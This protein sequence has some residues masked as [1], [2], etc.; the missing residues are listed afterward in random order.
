MDLDKLNKRAWLIGMLR[1][2][3]GRYPPKYLTKIEA[4][5]ERGKYKCS[6]CQELFGPKQIQIDHTVPVID[7]EK[8][9]TNWD[10]YINRMF[11]DK[12]GF[13]AM[14]KPCHKEKSDKENKI[15]K[16]TRKVKKSVDK[17]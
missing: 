8:G 1:R 3:S 15:R 9:F 10:D 4:R 12:E 14:C 11:C 2:I 5:V 6:K 13:S 16:V 7:P 17:V